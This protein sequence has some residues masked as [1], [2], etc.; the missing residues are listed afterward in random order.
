MSEFAWID[1][2]RVEL[3]THEARMRQ[4]KH[5]MPWPPP[6]LERMLI[7]PGDD[8]AVMRAGRGDL[9][10]AADM[11]MEG[12]HF[13]LRST[14]PQMVGRKA[15][16]VNLSDLAAMAGAP[17]SA[18][19]CLAL[20]KVGG[21]ALAK[22]LYSG[23]I[24][25]AEEFGLTI[26]GGD[27]NAW[28]GPLVVSV[29]ITG[30]AHPHGSVTRSGAAAGDWICV[31]G[32]LGGSLT[33]RHLSFR[34]RLQEAW[35]LHADYGL[36]AMLDL[37]DGL[38]GD[39]RHIL[40]AS[41]VGAWLDPIGLP[42]SLEAQH[43]AKLDSAVDARHRALTDGE[44]FEL[45]FTLPAAAAQQ[46]LAAQPLPGVPISK[47]GEITAATGLLWQGGEAVPDGGWLHRF[48]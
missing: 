4:A 18:T 1:W 32:T 38:A 6:D 28:D 27:T 25:L 7:A 48:T 43:L 34:P 33:G 2:L 19:I 16:A 47:I 15:L 45:C 30:R 12:V 46:L 21:A 14:T 5:H 23:L 8:A 40:A 35:Q 36:S 37:S 3:A 22:A 42:V 29:A 31:T 24:P 44:D 11:L 10:L 9:L 41:G 26:A 17:E 20:P 39:L 13:D